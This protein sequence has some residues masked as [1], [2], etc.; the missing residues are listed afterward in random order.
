MTEQTKTAREIKQGEYVKRNASAAKVYIRGAYDRSTKTIEL[1]DFD[2]MNRQ[3]W[4][5]PST[6]LLIGFFF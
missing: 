2:D 1:T 6:P 3:I 5:K 4:V